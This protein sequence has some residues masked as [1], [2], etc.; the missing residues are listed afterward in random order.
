MATIDTSIYNQQPTT[1][2]Q[3]PF[4]LQ[5]QM[6]Q[7][8]A[9]RDQNKLTQMQFAEK[10]RQDSERNVLAGAYRDSYNPDGSQDRNKLYKALAAGGQGQLVPGLQKQYSEADASGVELE[11]KRLTGRKQQVENALQ[12]LG[13]TEQIMAGVK[14]QASYEA[15]LP[16][17]RALH[18]PETAAKIPTVFDPA[19]IERGRMQALPLKERLANEWKTLEYKLNTERFKYQQGNDAANRGVTMRGQDI[20]SSNAAAGRAVTMRGQD[21]ADAR[22]AVKPTAPGNW[23]YDA[24]SDEWVMPPSPEFPQGQRSGSVAKTN[25]AKSMDY[26]ISQFIGNKKNPGPIYTATTGGPLGAYGKA[27]RVTNSQE[28]MRF[29]NLREQMSTELRTLFRIPGEGTLS[30]REQAQYGIQLPDVKY[31]VKTNENIVKDVQERIKI[32]NSPRA[33]PYSPKGAKDDPLGLR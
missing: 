17:L 27:G 19:A 18:D 21:M 5:A 32:R 6:A 7:I 20:S 1:R 14:D 22:A 28:A 30:D 8:Q 10:A 29:D 25:A 24:G 23:K 12:V 2:I 13:A 31:S 9:G 11:N 15:V 33:N 16:Q 26:V 4:E 3:T